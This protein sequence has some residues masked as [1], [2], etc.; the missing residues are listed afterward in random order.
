MQ[1]NNTTRRSEQSQECTNPF[2]CLVTLTFDLLT[3]VGFQDSLWN[4]SMSRLVSLAAS[5]FEISCGQTD[6]HTNAAVGV[7]NSLTSVKSVERIG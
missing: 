7:G 2:L 6:K 3:P 5:V 1:R 4:I